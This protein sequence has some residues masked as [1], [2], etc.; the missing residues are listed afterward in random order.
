MNLKKDLKTIYKKLKKGNTF[1]V[2]FLLSVLLW[3]PTS[4]YAQP[5]TDEQLAA[6]YFQEEDFEKAAMYY[7]RLYNSNQSDFYYDYYLQCLIKLEDYKEAKKLAKN[8]IKINPGKFDY[9]I[10]LGVVYLKEEEEK[11]A[12]KQFEETIESVPPI[13]SK[14]IQLANVFVEEGLY[15]KALDTYAYGD[16]ILKGTYPFNFEKARLYGR[17]GKYEQMF[18]EYLAMLDLSENYL[19]TIQNEL[20][21]NLAFEEGS[22]QNQ[23]LKQALLK[24]VQRNPN[25]QVYSELLIWVYLQEKNYKLALIQSKALDQRLNE[26][27]HRLMELAQLARS[28]EDND[29]AVE[30]LEY[31]VDKGKRSPFYTDARILLMD[32]LTEKVTQEAQFNR[33]DGLKLEQTYFTTI[34]DIGLNQKTV[35][36]QRNLAHLQAFYL[37]KPDTAVTL[38]EKALEIPRISEQERAQCK[39]ELADIY[40]IKGLIWDASLLYSQVDKAFKYDRLGE[41]A[42]FKN[43]KVSYYTGDFNWAKAQLDVLKGSTSKLIANDAMDLSLLITDNTGVDTTVKP[44]EI[45]ARADLLTFQNEFDKA[46]RA[47]DSISSLYPGHALTD[48]VLLQKYELYYKRGQVDTAL[49]FLKQIATEHPTD[50]TADD[51]LFLLGKLYEEFYKNKEKA[52]E[53]YQ[54]LMINHT[55]SLYVVE[56]RKR[57]R[58]LRGDNQNV[59][60]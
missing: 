26:N 5:T 57:F 56:A 53:W 19:Q 47:L 27:G 16:K 39:L 24:R 44:M 40:L 52:M 3:V 20:A 33:E 11:K 55:N 41:I 25:R 1:Y 32:V 30:A 17:L 38:L 51:A 54:E 23:L 29:V 4:S 21:R 12:E 45:F 43:A 18:S 42:K 7:E 6:Y 34:Q 60:Q 31:I 10:D 36:L 46:E 8:Q 2:L 50:I 59:E 9:Q 13:G 28:N 58:A 15:Q 22:E 35:K 48:E 37:N 14:I 49:T